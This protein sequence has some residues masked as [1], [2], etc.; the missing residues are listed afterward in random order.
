MSVGSDDFPLVDDATM[1]SWRA[2]ARANPPNLDDWAH[3]VGMLRLCAEINSHSASNPDLPGAAISSAECAIR[4]VVSFLQK[5]PYLNLRGEAVAP[6]VRLQLAMWDLTEGRAPPMLKPVSGGRGNPGKGQAATMI[7]GIA[8]R[9]LSEFIEAR[10]P[11]R[12][13][14]RRIAH[15]LNAASR[16]G[17]GKI[18][19]ATVI[20]WRDRLKQGPGPGA[21]DI[22]VD[23]YRAALPLGMGE[24]PLARAENLL[25]VLRDRSA[26]LV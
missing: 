20:N 11:P 13:A 3:L 25:V 24:T 26:A 5:Q 2:E 23:H 4:A 19:G 14:A 21:P 1:A 7:Q 16:R 8:A 15:A 18:T 12:E 6:L 9:T 17:M 10:V 22:A